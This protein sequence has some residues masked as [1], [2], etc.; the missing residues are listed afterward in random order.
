M[1]AGPFTAIEGISMH[2]G[3]NDNL[4]KASIFSIFDQLMRSG[5][6]S[7]IGFRALVMINVS[8]LQVAHYHLISNTGL[9]E[10]I[11]VD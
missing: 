2:G 6:G 5:S 1:W 7:W 3:T 10:D 4:Y 8:S 9:V 11:M